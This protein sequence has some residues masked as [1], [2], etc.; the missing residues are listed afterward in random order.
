MS[1]SLLV[2]W[3][4][5]N[6]VREIPLDLSTTPIEALI[7]S[8]DS[9]FTRYPGEGTTEGLFTIFDVPKQKTYLLRVGS[10][11]IQS[12]KRRLDLGFARLGRQDA[13]P[14][15][16]HTP[17]S[18]SLLNLVPWNTG[19][20]IEMFA[21]NAG[22]SFLGALLNNPPPGA[23]THTGTVD[24]FLAQSPREL[25]SA[26]GDVLYVSQ[27]ASRDQ[28]PD[29]I[30]EVVSAAVID[31][32]LDVENGGGQLIDASMTSLAGSKKF[33]V[34]W[35][36]AAFVDL[37]SSMGPGTATT[38]QSGS[39]L[40]ASPA[41]PSWGVL[42]AYPTL[43]G[44]RIEST[45]AVTLSASFES[46]FPSHWHQYEVDTLNAIFDLRGDGTLFATA[47]A[48]T[49]SE[50]GRVS[51]G[52]TPRLSAPAM[53]TLDDMSMSTTLINVGMTPLVAWQ[54][55]TLGSADGYEIRIEE[56]SPGNRIAA[57]FYT[58]DTSLVL[59]DGV[60]KKDGLY[61][62]ILAARSTPGLDQSFS[63]LRQTIPSARAEYVSAP[64]SP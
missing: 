15:V 62:A 8:N 32:N 18:T 36:P 12:A 52:A 2:T 46:P 28:G 22:L 29:T 16:E 44:A 39:R 53:P 27:V 64:F 58:T 19:H 42:T 14:I 40:V 61:I 55:P 48:Q 47:R 1:G 23:T 60:L 4:T 57:T 50:P 54:P 37:F 56:L 33:E 35:D 13:K 7:L 41:D 5:E 9:K 31:N 11:Y 3:V 51:Q 63:P 25:D 45:S 38:T 26:D 21:P 17:V 49:V 6:E 34:S 59:P 30:T 24:F 10:L 43:A 20:R